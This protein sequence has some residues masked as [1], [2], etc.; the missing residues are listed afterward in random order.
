MVAVMVAM[1]GAAHCSHRTGHLD[2]HRGLPALT[3]VWVRFGWLPKLGDN[4][5]THAWAT[6]GDIWG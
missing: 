4:T 6:G 2:S 5:P 3:A 1:M